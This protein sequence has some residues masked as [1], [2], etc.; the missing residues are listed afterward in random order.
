MKKV[1]TDENK[2]LKTLGTT[3][4]SEHFQIFLEQNL[5]RMMN[6]SYGKDRMDEVLA[7][8]V[9][10]EYFEFENLGLLVTKNVEHAYDIGNNNA[11]YVQDL[12]S[13]EYVGYLHLNTD[14]HGG[15]YLYASDV[16]KESVSCSYFLSE[17]G[18]VETSTEREIDWGKYS[19]KKDKNEIDAEEM[20]IRE[21]TFISV[22]DGGIELETNCKVDMQSRKVFDIEP[23]GAQN[24]V[25]TLDKEFIQFDD[26][27][28]FE[29]MPVGENGS[30]WYDEQGQDVQI[31]DEDLEQPH[32][33]KM[34]KAINIKWDIDHGDNEFLPTEV[35][36]PDGM[37]DEDEISD[38][39]SDVTGFCHG[40]FELTTDVELN[41]NEQPA[42]NPKDYAASE[43]VMGNLPADKE[44]CL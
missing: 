36:I 26:G 34:V 13:G 22:W 32:G 7:R 24:F 12:N 35:N 2:M 16:N 19:F 18:C 9:V 33:K 17:R 4:D 5:K 6:P 44:K 1:Y 38:Y 10:N 41:K 21:A 11:Y 3:V 25:N 15:M 23:S 43:I 29:V 39:I 40:G 20:Y 42:F 14:M 37:E 8:K 27:T 30:F 28:K 31:R